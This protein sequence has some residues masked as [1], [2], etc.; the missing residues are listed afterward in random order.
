MAADNRRHR[1]RTGPKIGRA[2]SEI[3]KMFLTPAPQEVVP[4]A[5]IRSL[6]GMTL[7]RKSPPPA[8]KTQ[9]VALT[10]VSGATLRRFSVFANTRQQSLETLARGCLVRRVAPNTRVVRTGEPASYVYLVYSG[11]LNVLTGNE[12]GREAI[13]A[14]LKQGEMFGEMAVL[15]EHSRCATVAAATQCVLICISKT[16]FKNFM[17]DNFEVSQHIMRMLIGRL[18]AA[19]RRIESLALLEVPGRVMCVLRELAESE[20]GEQLTMRKHSIQEIAKMVGASRE[21]VSRVM[22]DLVARGVIAWVDRRI[23]LR[24]YS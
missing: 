10:S 23:V 14:V 16:D 19:N 7:P 22:K 21:M 1:T 18:R 13:I 12:D 5:A 24:S 6:R 20:G 3:D 2:P 4:D 15:D 11:S 17:K 9:D 8:A